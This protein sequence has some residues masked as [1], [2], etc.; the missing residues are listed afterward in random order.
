MRRVRYPGQKAREREDEICTNEVNPVF[1]KAAAVASSSKELAVLGGEKQA[2]KSYD[3]PSP[4]HR[5]TAEASLLHY[6][7]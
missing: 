2:S 6:T 4:V 5:L 7:A 3:F 1:E